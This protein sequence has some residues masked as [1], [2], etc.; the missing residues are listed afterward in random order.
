MQGGFASGSIVSGASNDGVS[1]SSITIDG[2]THATSA[3]NPDG[4]TIVTTTPQQ[5]RGAKS[6]SVEP[7]IE[8]AVGGWKEN[9]LPTVQV[10][11]TPDLTFNSTN[12]SGIDTTTPESLYT[13]ITSYNFGTG[14]Q[15][16]IVMSFSDDEQ[17]WGYT[18][19]ILATYD[20]NT[21]SFNMV[22]TYGGSDYDL[23]LTFNSDDTIV[24]EFTNES[25]FLSRSYLKFDIDILEETIIYHPLDAKFIPIDSSTLALNGSGELTV[26]GGGSS[27]GGS[28]VSLTSDNQG[29]LTAVTVSDGDNVDVASVQPVTVNSYDGTH[30]NTIK[31]GSGNTYQFYIPPVA[32]GTTIVNTNNLWSTAIGGY[33]ETTVTPPV[34]GADIDFFDDTACTGF[35]TASEPVW[36]YTGGTEGLAQAMGLTIYQS[37]SAWA[38]DAVGGCD[39]S[40]DYSSD[41]GTSWTNVISFTDTE[42]LAY[43]ASG[44]PTIAINANT[45]SNRVSINTQSGMTNQLRAKVYVTSSATTFDTTNDI[46]RMSLT[47]PGPGT[48]GSTTTV[49]HPIDPQYIAGELP[50]VQGTY[51]LKCTVD[52]QG[53][54]TISWEI[55]NI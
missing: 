17:T 1:W 21:V 13:Q 25:L 42:V 10:W 19:P 32:D 4:R 54:P 43:Y 15:A 45:G 7:V 44:N 37:G 36:S 27:S 9:A 48:P 8:T 3:T 51:V 2:V 30:A 12:Y 47:F 50:A 46:V 52:A 14:T 31:V 5:T 55:E 38:S 6:R 35:K 40:I 39:F 34:P 29:R 33:T 41:G 11:E 49:V 18:E 24:A 22:F 16:Q 26:I 20:D 28:T 53:N 23:T